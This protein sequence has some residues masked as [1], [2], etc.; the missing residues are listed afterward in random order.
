M[1]NVYS[2]VLDTL[3]DWEI[4]YVTA[5][6]NSGQYFKKQSDKVSVKTVGAT[7]ESI[8]TKGGMKVI[9]EI[10]TDEIILSPSTVLLLPGADTWDDPRHKPIIEKATE[11]L[12]CGATV[13]AICG[14]TTALAASGVFDERIHTSNS[15][16]YLKMICPNYKGEAYYRNVKAVSDN[17]LI[18]ASSAGGLLFA[19]I[20][21]AK[22]DV[23]SENTLESWYNYFNT[24][25]PKYFYNLMDTLTH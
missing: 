6:L 12:E 15:L 14:A 7:K 5:E 10:T 19:R 9:P 20:I 11:L 21:L 24:G 23:Y 2:Y 25:D 3:A 4:G 22:I 16:E 13:A 1:I 18:T 8:V 17:N